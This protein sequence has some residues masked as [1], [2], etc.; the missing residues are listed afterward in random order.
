MGDRKA[1]G[2]QL[3]ALA[4]EN[5]RASAAKSFTGE[6]SNAQVDYSALATASLINSAL[7][8]VDM[9]PGQ[10]GVLSQIQKQT[11]AYRSLSAKLSANTLSAWSKGAM[12]VTGTS[13]ECK[14]MFGDEFTR[15]LFNGAD[16]KDPVYD[17]TDV[18]SGFLLELRRKYGNDWG[19]AMKAAEFLKA[20]QDE[21]LHKQVWDRVPANNDA[22][23]PT[24]RG[25]RGNPDG[26]GRGPHRF[27]G[28]RF[29]GY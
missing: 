21:N 16:G 25:W 14:N 27:G 20:K 9:A 12:L 18:P 11:A 29:A 8:G 24:H 17:A 19:A 7:A 23:D 13:K 28:S 26:G 2:P 15:Q 22:W 5:A 1:G 10:A 6:A 4:Q 3:E